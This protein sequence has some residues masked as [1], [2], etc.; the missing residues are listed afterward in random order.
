[1]EENWNPQRQILIQIGDLI[2]K[3]PHSGACIKYWRELEA[4]HGKDR[5]IMLKGN[6]EQSFIADNVKNAKKP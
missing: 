5:V 4:F 3:G 6:H 2:N 1:M